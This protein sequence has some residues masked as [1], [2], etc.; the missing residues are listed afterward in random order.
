MSPRQKI[1][2][3]I[4][5]RMGSSRLP[6]KS[7]MAIAGKPN[8]ARIISR[9]KKCKNLDDIIVATSTAPD[10][11]KIEECA[12]KENVPCYRGSEDDVL[13]RVVQAHKKMNSEI[14]VE[15]TGDS[16]LVDPELIDMGIETYLNNKCDVVSNTE[17]VTFPLGIDIQVFSLSLLDEVEKNIQ[18]PQVREHVSLYFYQHPEKYNIIHLFAPKKWHAPEYRFMLDYS[19]DLDFLEKVYQE[20]E[21]I[22]GN[23]FGLEEIMRL[24]K[25][26]PQILDLNRSRFVKNKI[27]T[28][29]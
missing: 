18:D 22:Y 23:D 20:L 7:L 24:L 19:E 26:K 13:N 5:A 12:T 14:I 6:G 9:L 3:S 29:S 10:D 15:I 8:L 25:I 16:S 11:D 27:A 4:E 2:A 21:P 1:V 28:A 17:K